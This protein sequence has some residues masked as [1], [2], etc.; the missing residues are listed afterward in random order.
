MVAICTVSI[1]LSDPIAMSSMPE[2]PMIDSKN[3][4]F[5]SMLLK[6]PLTNGSHLG[7][8]P[9][10]NVQSYFDHTTMSGMPENPVV[11][12]KITNLPLL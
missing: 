9:Q 2:N 5:A 3:E 12:T 8:Y 6:M 11:D 1:V 4:E 7:F 10:F